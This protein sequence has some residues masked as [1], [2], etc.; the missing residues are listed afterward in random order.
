MKKLQKNKKIGLAL[1]GGAVLGAAHIGVLKA[2]EELEIEIGWITGTSI[3]SL[4]ASLYAFGVDCNKVQD[5]AIDL[6]WSDIAGFSLSKF[7][8]LSNKNI[9]KFLQ[10]HIGDATFDQAN[11]PLAVIATNITT[12]QKVVLNKGKVAYAVMASCCI[13]GIFKPVTI[14][15]ILLVDGGIVENVPVSPLKDLGADFLSQ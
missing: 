3:G 15:D 9:Q 14:N 6:S 1:G 10:K 8:L 7:G 12:G 2:L 4:V 11:I 5:L 13:P